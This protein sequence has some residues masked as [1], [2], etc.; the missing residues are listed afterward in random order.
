MFV[1]IIR[2]NDALANVSLIKDE[3][4]IILTKN[5][6]AIRFNSNEIGSTSR[7]S[8]GVKG[9]NLVD[10]EIVCVLPLRDNNDYLGLF[11]QNGFAKKVKLS[12]LPAQKRGGRGINLY[13]VDKMTG[14]IVGGS[15]I[16]DTDNLFIGG[17]KH[18]ICIS[19]K[20]IPLQ[21]RNAIGNQLI[22]HGNI[23][24]ITKV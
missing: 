1:V 9:I 19:A 8:S 10:D 6:Y 20:D 12:E 17:D 7:N 13:K 14:P 15:L 24:S 5:G 21:G 2:E 4:L 18:N 3:Q 22:K 16:N 11:T 23:S